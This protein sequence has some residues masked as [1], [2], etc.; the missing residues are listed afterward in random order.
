M[1]DETIIQKTYEATQELTREVGGQAVRLTN[2]E[3]TIK[4]N[5]KVAEEKIIE[6]RKIL[7]DNNG[8]AVVS[9]LLS[10]EEWRNRVDDG[11]KIKEEHRFQKSLNLLHSKIVLWL[12]LGGLFLTLIS[13]ATD[14]YLRLHGS[15]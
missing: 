1:S 5:T 14:I 10:L 9:R 15:K 7:I 11:E 6:L 2:I 13:F 4:D 3:Q 8:K 12:G